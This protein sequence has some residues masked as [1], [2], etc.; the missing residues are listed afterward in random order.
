MRPRVSRSTF[1][2]ARRI[3]LFGVWLASFALLLQTVLPLLNRP[4][5]ADALPFANDLVLCTAHGLA[6]V[7]DTDGAS[8]DDSDAPR[9]PNCPLCQ[10]W[11]KLG[12]SVPASVAN[13][14]EP[15]F[16]LSPDARAP[17]QAALPRHHLDPLQARAPPITT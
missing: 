17:S 4:A 1:R 3:S 8:H 2:K 6:N 16:E 5:L 15:V 14:L 13:L 10:V 9:K 11:Q 7:S 12:N